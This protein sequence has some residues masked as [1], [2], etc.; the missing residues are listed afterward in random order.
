LNEPYT[1]EIQIVVPS[2]E[3]DLAAG[4]DGSMGTF[5]LTECELTTRS[6]PLDWFS[7]DNP[8]PDQLVFIEVSGSFSGTAQGA[9]R[10][11]DGEHIEGVSY[12]T[13]GEFTTGF[14]PIFPGADTLDYLERH[15]VGGYQLGVPEP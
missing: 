6:L 12:A 11:S 2:S 10:L 15:C 3:G 8:G 4:A 9:I 5:V 14:T 1:G 13:S 7:P